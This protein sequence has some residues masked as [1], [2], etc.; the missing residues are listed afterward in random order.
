MRQS[1]LARNHHVDVIPASQAVV[2]NRQQTVGIGR[3][4]NAHDVSLLVDHMVEEAGI[5][6]RVS[7]VILL[8]D[9]G[10]EK[11]VQRRDFPAPW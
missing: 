9:V 2:E 7:I 6:V 1:V 11:V 4:V 8:S 10:S 3:K 5:L